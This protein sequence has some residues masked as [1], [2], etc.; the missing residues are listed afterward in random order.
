[1]KA[2]DKIYIVHDKET[3]GMFVNYDKKD[4]N[5]IEYINKDLLLEWAKDMEKR[6]E[7]KFDDESGDM[8]WGYEVAI[9]EVIEKLES[10]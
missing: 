4:T 1:M 7:Y 8:F 6:A 10:L 9:G 3:G 2:P 5:N